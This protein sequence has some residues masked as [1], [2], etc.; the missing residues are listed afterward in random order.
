VLV[1]GGEVAEREEL[2]RSTIFARPKTG[3]VN[4]Q[5]EPDGLY[6]AAWDTLTFTPRTQVEQRLHR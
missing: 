6:L 2:G 4:A 3:P 1:L 5:L